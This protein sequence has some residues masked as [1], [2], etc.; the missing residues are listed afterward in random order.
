MKKKPVPDYVN[1]AKDVMAVWPWGDLD[2]FDLQDIALAHKL[3][4]PAE[5]G[6]NPDLH[7][8]DEEYEDMGGEPGDEYYQR[9]Y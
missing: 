5:G 2:G 7:G 8:I 4:I 3:I 6:Y 1:F 9:N